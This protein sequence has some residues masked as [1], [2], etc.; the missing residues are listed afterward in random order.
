MS[1]PWPSS[2]PDLGDY[3]EEDF[4]PSPDKGSTD[5]V[6]DDDWVTD[7]DTLDLN[8]KTAEEEFTEGDIHDDSVEEMM[9]GVMEGGDQAGRHSTHSSSSGVSFSSDLGRRSTTGRRLSRHTM[10]ALLRQTPV[11]T[12]DEECSREESDEGGVLDSGRE[13]EVVAECR[14]YVENGG[15]PDY[16][17]PES[18]SGFHSEGGDTDEE[19]SFSRLVL[20]RKS[21]YHP[22]QERVSS[23]PGSESGIEADDEEEFIAK[24][25]TIVKEDEVEV[26]GNGGLDVS[27]PSRTAV[28][29]CD[30][31]IDKKTA[32]AV[33]REFL[34]TEF[35]AGFNR[36]WER[37]KTRKA[38]SIN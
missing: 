38:E 25:R 20:R 3:R 23:S 10:N 13:H 31:V 29:N 21:E 15:S 4:H 1:D 27:A 30:E 19:P 11:T 32:R 34:E 9:G 5:G 28:D 16:N 6:G 12:D 7:S 33:L 35:D 8:Y 24:S 26:T 14:N 22:N 18:F 37:V 17:P 2:A 36:A